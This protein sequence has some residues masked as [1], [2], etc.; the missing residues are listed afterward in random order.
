MKLDNQ[1][2]NYNYRV[3]VF[4]LNHITGEEKLYTVEFP[5]FWLAKKYAEAIQYDKDITN[6]YLL[7]RMSDD[8]FDITRKFK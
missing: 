7:E 4:F 6:I 1:I 3:D 8:N 5:E 2:K